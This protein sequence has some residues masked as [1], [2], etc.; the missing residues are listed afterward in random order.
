MFINGTQ[1]V[2]IEDAHKCKDG[3]VI[4]VEEV[5]GYYIR[6]SPHNL[7]QPKQPKQREE[8]EEPEVIWF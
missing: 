4:E 2:K 8:T 1:Y 5:P 3:F 7:N 6:I